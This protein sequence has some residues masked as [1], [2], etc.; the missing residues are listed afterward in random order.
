[1]IVR[2]RP[3]G[4]QEEE[5]DLI[6]EKASVNSLSILDHTFTFD[7]EDIFRLVGLPLVENC[8]AGFNSSIFAYGQTGSGKTYTMWGPPSVMS[9]GASSST[10][11][12]LTPRVFERLFSRIDEEQSKHSDKQ[13]NYQCRCSFLEASIYNEQI[14]DL[15]EPTQRNL[16]IRE[17]VRTGVYVDYLTEE[18]V[19]TMKDVNNLLLKVKFTCYYLKLLCSYMLN[20]NKHHIRKFHNC[21]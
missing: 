6:V 13:L 16:Q 15:L 19:S 9:E 18:Y 2:L 4:K 14:T 7:S 20:I 21:L 12:G 5:A 11:R 17:D 3:P 8:L 1:V 10:D